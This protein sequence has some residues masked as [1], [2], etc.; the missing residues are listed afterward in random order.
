MDVFGPLVRECR[1]R[2]SSSCVSHR[3]WRWSV[4]RRLFKTKN[5]LH[6]LFTFVD[7][8]SASLSVPIS[9]KKCASFLLWKHAVMHMV[10]CSLRWAFR[11]CATAHES[12]TVS[13]SSLL[14][15]GDRPSSPRWTTKRRVSCSALVLFSEMC[16]MEYASSNLCLSCTVLF[17]TWNKEVDHLSP[18]DWSPYGCSF[19]PGEG[20]RRCGGLGVRSRWSPL[21]FASFLVIVA[22][23]CSEEHVAPLEHE[24]CAVCSL[25]SPC[26]PSSVPSTGTTG[27]ASSSESRPLS[28]GAMSVSSCRS[29]RMS[30]TSACNVASRLG[31]FRRTWSE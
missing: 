7:V 16:R 1:S 5:T 14:R 29:S 30:V 17:C 23:V 24:P 10:W 4:H 26:L 25:Q 18:R 11:L 19:P 28:V 3:L 8:S 2:D 21:P 20:C 12:L 6:S 9:Q 13:P 15:L 27:M 22:I 31:S